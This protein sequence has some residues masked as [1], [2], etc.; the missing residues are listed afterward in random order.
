MASCFAFFQAPLES[1]DAVLAFISKVGEIS[2][3]PS[4]LR[5]LLS[6]KT[7]VSDLGSIETMSLPCVYSQL[8][9]LGVYKKRKSKN[10]L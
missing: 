10:T 7:T 1:P 2:N 4:S 9:K 5:N 6:H 3:V 8:M